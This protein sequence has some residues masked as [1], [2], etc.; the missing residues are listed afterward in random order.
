MRRLAATAGFLLFASLLSAT[1]AMSAE[2]RFRWVAFGDAGGCRGECPRVIEAQ[3]TITPDTPAAFAE[4]VRSSG[5][6]PSARRVVLIHSPGGVLRAG[7]QL[8]MM[9][10]QLEMAVFV[11]RFADARTLAEAGVISAAEARR[12]SGRGDRPVAGTCVSACVYAFLGGAERVVPERSRIGV[13]R[14]FR[15]ED[16]YDRSPT[17]D[18]QAV[19]AWD[20]ATVEEMQRNY[21]ES[22]GADPGLVRVEQGV[23]SNSVR[24]LSAQ[25]LRR[26]RIVTRPR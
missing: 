3:G 4:F 13:H 17:H 19:T 5:N 9:F 8:G 11:G 18:L 22:M 1:P 14:P 7:M 23:S 20:R 15:A 25:D 24:F 26:L 16:R 2:M 12:A 21:I 10:R 6:I